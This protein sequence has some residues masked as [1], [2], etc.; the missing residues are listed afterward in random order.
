MVNLDDMLTQFERH[1]PGETVTVSVWR[2]GQTRKASLVLG[3]SD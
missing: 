2:A 3:G 1:Q